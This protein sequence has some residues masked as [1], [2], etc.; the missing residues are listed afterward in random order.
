MPNSMQL[1]IISTTDQPI[2]AEIVQLY[3]PAYLGQTGILENHRPYISL[4][5]A[6]E[7]FYT[8]TQN[9]INRLYIGGGFVEANENHVI[10]ISDIV[11]RGENLVAQREKIDTLSADVDKKIKALQKIEPGMTDEQI[12]AMP[13]ELEIALEEQNQLE[14][15]KKIIQ[16]IQNE[17]K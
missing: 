9:K 3:I 16:A 10:I 11:E 12:K 6:G 1:E 13:K 4:L 17:K 15:K 14:I 7:V 8:D 5:K 2:K